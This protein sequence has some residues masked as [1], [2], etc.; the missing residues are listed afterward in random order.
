MGGPTIDEAISFSPRGSRLLL[1]RET[2]GGYDPAG[3]RPGRHRSSSGSADP[4]RIPGRSAWSAARL[5]WPLP[6]RSTAWRPSPCAGGRD[7]ERDVRDRQAAVGAAWRPADRGQLAV[8]GRSTRHGAVVNADGTGLTRLEV[9]RDFLEDPYEALSPAWSPDGRR[10]G[11]HRLV[12]TPAQGN[13]NVRQGI[14]AE[15]DRYAPD[16]KEPRVVGP[17]VQEKALVAGTGFEPVTFGL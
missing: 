3:R 5:S 11:F 2:E 1:A 10:I 4:T 13:G 15:A 16:K 12:D 17:G 6:T 14:H 9:P 7:C 8:R